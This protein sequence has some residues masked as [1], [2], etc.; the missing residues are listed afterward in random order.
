MP[1]ELQEVVAT[2]LKEAVTESFQEA[3]DSTD[4]P[5]ILDRSLIDHL[6]E[7]NIEVI[8]DEDLGPVRGIGALEP[9]FG[10]FIVRKDP[11]ANHTLSVL[12]LASAMAAA[13]LPRWGGH[14][15]VFDRL[16]SEDPS[17]HSADTSK[18]AGILE[19]LQ[20]I[21]EETSKDSKFTDLQPTAHQLI[22]R[23]RQVGISIQP[24]E[25]CPIVY[26]AENQRMGEARDG[27]TEIVYKRLA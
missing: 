6:R 4:L 21:F 5:S 10:V 20:K 22:E 15:W 1:S 9:D 24:G 26:E 8:D 14:I 2:H 27:T 12:G 23:I 13:E 25:H 11:P 18:S 3:H 19:L 16:P 7:A 17:I